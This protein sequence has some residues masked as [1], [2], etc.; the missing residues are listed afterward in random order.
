MRALKITP[1]KVKN[2]SWLC[3]EANMVA[4]DATW[5]SVMSYHVVAV[6][7]EFGIKL[8]KKELDLFS[9]EDVPMYVLKINTSTRKMKPKQK[10]ANRETIPLL[11]RFFFF[12]VF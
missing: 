5:T 12:T 1:V 8:S 4:N 10:V 9:S 7:S 3:I 2:S 6:S 11:N